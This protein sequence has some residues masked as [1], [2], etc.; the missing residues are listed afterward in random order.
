MVALAGPSVSNTGTIVANGGR[1]GMAAANAV[2]VDVEGD[3][4]LFFQT[5]ATEAKN[6]LEQLG[7]IQADGGSIE[8]RAAAR[9]A[10][11]DTVLN[12]TGIVQARTI[13]SRE[14]RIVID[15][16]GE[17]IVA[18]SGRVDATGLAAGERGGSVSVEGQRVLLDNG[19]LVDASGSAGGGSIRV[20]GDFHGANPEVRNAEVDRRHR[21]R[22]RARRCD[23]AGHGGTVAIW[24]DGL[25][26]FYGS[27]SAHAA[28]NAAATAASSR[29]RASSRSSSTATSTP[30]PR[31]ARPGRCSSIPTNIIIVD[32]V[33]RRKRHDR[34]HGRR[35]H[36][37]HDVTF[38]HRGVDAGH[39]VGH[40]RRH[41]RHDGGASPGAGTITIDSAVVWGTANS[42]TFKAQSDLTLNPGV[43]LRNTSSG[44]L[45][46]QADG[47]VLLNGSVLLGTGNLFV[48]DFAG[49]VAGATGAASF[50][51]GAGG[52]ITTAGGNVT[53]R[54]TGDVSL[55]AA[56]VTS[57]T[58]GATP[59][60]AGNV[61]ITAADGSI[62]TGGI[63]ANGG[64]GTS[65]AGGAIGGKGGDI[66][67]TVNGSLHTLN[68]GLISAL[69]GKGSDNSTNN[70]D[71]RTG[72]AGGAVT[73]A[74][75]SG[76]A[77]TVGAIT[78]SGGDAGTGGNGNSDGGDGGAG[79]TISVT[80]NGGA[81]TVANLTTV[82]GAETPRHG[83]GGNQ[84]GTPGAGG[85]VA[86]TFAQTAPGH[87]RRQR[88][89]DHRRQR[90]RDRRTGQRTLVLIDGAENITLASALLTRS[91]LR[92]PDAL[93]HHQRE[94]HHRHR[95]VQRLGLRRQR[96]HP[97]HRRLRPDH[98]QRRQHHAHRACRRQRLRRRRRQRRRT[99]DGTTFVG[100][101]NLAGG[102]G[103]DTFTVNGS[104]SLAGSITGG[105]GADTLTVTTATAD[106]VL[107]S[108]TSGTVSN[109]GGGYSGI[110]SSSATARRRRSPARHRLDL[111]RHRP[112]HRRRERL[113]DHDV[114]ASFSLA[115]G[116][117]AD[118]L[119]VQRRRRAGGQ[120][121]WRPGSA[122]TL[123]LSTTGGAANFTLT[124]PTS[125][126]RPRSAAAGRT[127]PCWSA[128]TP[129]RVSPAATSRRPGRSPAT[130]SERDD[131]SVTTNFTGVTSLVG[132]SAADAFVIA[133]GSRSRR[134][135]AAPAATR[136]PRPR[137]RPRT[138]RS[139]T[140]SSTGPSRRT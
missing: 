105:G 82:G 67:I 106:F 23:D 81:L 110:A 68:T 17:G 30:A 28:A 93:G 39:A 47:A 136:S 128:T 115:G 108:A 137:R 64:V 1:V 49:S 73:L 57:G 48:S 102:A 71:G 56:V 51:T 66:S 46:L 95:H 113:R 129:T 117:A 41:R 6:R 22:G 63:T 21:G 12:M 91:D 120:R 10:F 62:S 16:G 114:P 33:T 97:V 100:I 109:V 29:C 116:T 112:R 126:P 54:T 4:L 99:I 55:G 80:S 32:D 122:N 103:G 140:P 14:G 89:D 42:L 40:Q 96:R 3:G 34:Q 138:S 78:A 31:R 123:D 92:Q 101:G 131:G 15:G 52:T 60:N 50:T 20:G 107:A 5:S 133:A 25:T 111:Q 127:S 119:H 59:T 86:L 43:Q 35:L 77:S 18:V 9:G 36:R 44:S 85:A 65:T 61:T 53:I 8:M 121:Q 83:G 74:N 72:G 58:G 130:T 132:G 76:G 139:A 11:A 94:R 98:R 70:S 79:G 104:G 26:R 38:E 90:Q 45:N 125:A 7:R 24:S 135:T 87:A 27:I 88:L 13:G 75:L 84:D 134:S 124:W 69:G 19:S 37:S 118:S 2:S